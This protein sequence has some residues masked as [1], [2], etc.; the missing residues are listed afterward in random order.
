MILKFVFVLQL[1]LLLFNFAT[2]NNH[3]EIV[4]INHFPFKKDEPYAKFLN[5]KLNIDSNKNYRTLKINIEI[6]YNGMQNK[7]IF[8]H[9]KNEIEQTE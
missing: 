7:F 5:M 4:T 9:P 8:V 1:F 3:N 2:L 6:S